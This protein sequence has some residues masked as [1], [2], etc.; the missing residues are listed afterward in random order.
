MEFFGNLYNVSDRNIDYYYQSRCFFLETSERIVLE[1]IAK[2]EAKEKI[3]VPSVAHAIIESVVHKEGK[4]ELVKNVKPIV[5]YA[6]QRT[7]E[8]DIMISYC[9]AD[10][11]IT[12]KIYKFLI[13]QG[14]KIWIDLDNMYGPG[15]MILN[16]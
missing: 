6:D 14:F 5:N 10:K 8:Y 15:R 11:E 2:K 1:E 9:H 12:Q 3:V 13:E 16:N 4:K 7:F